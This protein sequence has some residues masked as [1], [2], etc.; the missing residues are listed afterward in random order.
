MEIIPDSL[1]A[2]YSPCYYHRITC[3]HGHAG[4]LYALICIHTAHDTLIRM[5]S[6]QMSRPYATRRQMGPEATEQ[7]RKNHFSLQAHGIAE[8]LC[9][10][11]WQCAC[12]MRAA[13]KRT[14]CS[15]SPYQQRCYID[16]H[17]QMQ[18][19]KREYLGHIFTFTCW[20]S[21]LSTQQHTAIVAG[22]ICRCICCIL[23]SFGDRTTKTNK[24]RR[25]RIFQMALKVYY[26]MTAK[27][28]WR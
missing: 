28:S 9:V 11:T 21:H 1:S 10:V 12:V 7:R 18:E 16:A 14:V 25:K 13:I 27:N 19:Y 3:T 26:I 6:I 22:W 8:T 2:S 24:K 23:F 5:R 15:F 4:W 20:P 17:M